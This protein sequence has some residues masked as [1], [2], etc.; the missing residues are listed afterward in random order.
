MNFIS[1]PSIHLTALSSEYLNKDLEFH[2]IG[3][4]FPVRDCLLYLR[5]SSDIGK[6]GGTGRNEEE[7]GKG[8]RNEGEVEE[9][10]GALRNNY[11]PIVQICRQFAKKLVYQRKTSQSLPGSLVNFHKKQS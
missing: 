6:R 10:E 4:R 2:I 5:Q 7:R 9:E 8:E 3:I 11:C 1:T